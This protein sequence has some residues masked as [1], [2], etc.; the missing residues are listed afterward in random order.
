MSSKLIWSPERVSKT[1]TAMFGV[2]LDRSRAEIVAMLTGIVLSM[3]VGY[4][5]TDMALEHVLGVAENPPD[6]WASIG[7]VAVTWL[8]Y[9]VG[10]AAL[11][12]L[13]VHR[14]MRQA[15][16]PETA[17]SVYSVILGVL[18][19]NVIWCMIPFLAV[20]RDT[21]PV[22]DFSLHIYAAATCLLVGSFGMKFWA[23]LHLG[24]E[25][26]YYEDMFLEER[27]ESGPV[28]EGPY[29]L[30][31]DPMYSIGYFPVYAGA[32]FAASFQGL[33]VAVIFHASIYAFS[34]LVER[35][36]VD[37]VYG[38]AMASTPDG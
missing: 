25:A 29:A 17:Y 37:R 5:A 4:Q 21:L 20:F 34:T 15:L 2:R 13:G 22:G 18:Y 38:T 9:Y 11:F 6:K 31:S 10:Q 32:L 12:R 16:G 7:Y 23:T 1:L 36:F 33:V 3:V 27:S 35:P 30:F 24:V 26:Y 14:K 8:A 19:F 28:T